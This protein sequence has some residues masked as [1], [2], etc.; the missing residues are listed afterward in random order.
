VG[1]K[2]IAGLDAKSEVR[3][4]TLNLSFFVEHAAEPDSEACADGG[5]RYLR[6]VKPNL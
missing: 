6:L 4:K 2:P 5:T 1:E 3:G